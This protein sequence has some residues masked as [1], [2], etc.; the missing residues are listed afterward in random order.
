VSCKKETYHVYAKIGLLLVSVVTGLMI[1]ASIIKG[2]PSIEKN[3]SNQVCLMVCVWCVRSD[4]TCLL[5]NRVNCFQC[6]KSKFL[7]S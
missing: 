2:V 6:R 7:I 5:N 3:C 1:R 4:I